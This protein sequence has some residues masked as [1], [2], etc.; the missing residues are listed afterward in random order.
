MSLQLWN[1]TVSD[2][3]PTK[4][5][6]PISREQLTSRAR[7]IAVDGRRPIGSSRTVAD[8]SL[9]RPVLKKDHS[10]NNIKREFHE[11]RQHNTVSKRV[12]TCLVRSDCALTECATTEYQDWRSIPSAFRSFQLLQNQFQVTVDDYRIKSR[13][14]RLPAEAIQRDL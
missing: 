14:G 7:D 13:P 5:Y 8:P 3:I 12:I 9:R 6:Y 2:C 1:D 11:T 10:K 4:S